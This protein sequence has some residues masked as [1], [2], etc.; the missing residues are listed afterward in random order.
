MG[1]GFRLAAPVAEQLLP[2]IEDRFQG[3]GVERLGGLAG[4]LAEFLGLGGAGQAGRGQ[5]GPGINVLGNHRIHLLQRLERRKEARR[6]VRLEIANAQVH[7]RKFDVRRSVVVGRQEKAFLAQHVA[8][9]VGRPR[10]QRRQP[11]LAFRGAEGVLP[12]QALKL[13]VDAGVEEQFPVVEQDLA[14]RPLLERLAAGTLEQDDVLRN[15]F[16]GSEPQF[17]AIGDFQQRPLGNDVRLAMGHAEPQARQAGMHPHDAPQQSRRHQPRRRFGRRHG[18]L[19]VG[20][21]DLGRAAL[22][23]EPFPESDHGNVELGTSN[24]VLGT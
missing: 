14:A 8:D 15:D 1:A 12:G 4:R 22:A 19:Q 24:L 13:P 5:E 11:F 20:Q 9:F 17:A 21:A 3:I 6:Q 23:A 10:A 16:R 2:R 7:G 18:L